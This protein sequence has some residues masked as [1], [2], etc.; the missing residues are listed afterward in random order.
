MTPEIP[1]ANWGRPSR[2]ASEADF[3]CASLCFELTRTLLL[4]FPCFLLPPC[5]VAT[6]MKENGCIRAILLIACSLKP[7]VCAWEVSEGGECLCVIYIHTPCEMLSVCVLGCLRCR[8][9]VR[10]CVFVSGTQEQNDS[11]WGTCCTC[12]LVVTDLTTCTCCD[13]IIVACF[14]PG[15][16]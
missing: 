5:D 10:V 16:L 12:W 15:T 11:Y 6:D 2:S 8:V 4:S 13:Y 3:L 9:C 7:D 1:A 14:P